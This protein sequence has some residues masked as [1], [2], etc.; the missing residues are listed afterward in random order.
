MPVIV[1]E[2]GSVIKK[3]RTFFFQLNWILIRMRVGEGDE[4]WKF[5]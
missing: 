3:I 4:D 1:Q 2:K 5:F